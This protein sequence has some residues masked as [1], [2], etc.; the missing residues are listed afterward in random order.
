ME[1]EISD[2]SMQIR[3][4]QEKVM[5]DHLLKRCAY[6]LVVPTNDCAVRARL[7][8]LGEPITLFGEREMERRDRL[9]MLMVNLDADELLLLQS[10]GD[11][12]EV[13]YD[14]AAGIVN[15]DGQ[16]YPFWTEGSEELLQARNYIAKYSIVKGALRLERARRRRDDPDEDFD[17]EVDCVLA[18]AGNLK[19]DRSEIDDRPLTGCSFSCDGESLATCGMSGAAKL[20]RMPGV[21]RIGAPLKG[22]TEQVTDVAFSPAA[23]DLL[24]TASADRTAILWNTEGACLRKFEGHF[25]RLARVAFHPSGKYVATAS[26]DK[27]WRLWDIETGVELLYQEGHSRSVY[28]VCFHYDGSLA[29]SCGLDSIVRVWDLRSGKSI[30]TFEGHNKAVYGIDFSPNGYHLATGG[31]DNTCRIW[32]LRK[33]EN[34]Y[35]IPAHSKQISQVKFDH[36]EGYFLSTASHDK[37]AKLWSARDFKPVRTLSGHD[38]IVSS[39]DIVGDGQYIATVSRDRTIKLWASCS[40]G[41]ENA[42]N[43]D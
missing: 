10:Q 15:S 27:S 32:N 3:E 36:V 37:T 19:L 8:R 39:I 29:A 35:I 12:E 16:C 4:R 33:K 24:A 2:S 31:E 7:H 14:A 1:Y 20:W 38:S 30:L 23:P 43:M 25:D 28:G 21:S 40:S 9:R 34:E 18:E 11:E 5:Q 42:M 6:A 13:A 41:K 22:H 17:G 26:F